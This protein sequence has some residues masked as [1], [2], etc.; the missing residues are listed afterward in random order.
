MNDHATTRARLRHERK[1]LLL[2]QSNNIKAAT[3]ANKVSNAAAT[4]IARIRH[5]M[6]LDGEA[7][8][9]AMIE[10][11]LPVMRKEME[12]AEQHGDNLRNWVRD[13]Q[14]GIAGLQKQ[15]NKF[16]LDIK[17]SERLLDEYHEKR[18]K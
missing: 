12:L 4:R 16:Y 6:R 7:L 18:D 14:K 10:D 13:K 9:I 11:E 1:L 5:L 15:I 3:A 2:T 17:S 8:Q